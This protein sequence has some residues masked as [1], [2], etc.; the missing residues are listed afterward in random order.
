MCIEAALSGAVMA[1]TR[2]R[3]SSLKANRSVAA[4]ASEAYPWRRARGSSAKPISTSGCESRRS[5]PH[6]PTGTPVAL[7][8]TAY[9][10]N[11]KRR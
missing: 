7:R 8:S 10:P 2:F 5:S 4:A 6:M 3:P 9:N 11:P 1:T